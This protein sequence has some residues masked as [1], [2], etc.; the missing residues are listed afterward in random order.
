MLVAN[1]LFDFD[2]L[3]APDE[4]FINLNNLPSTTH[5]R[6][7][8]GAHSLAKAVTHEPRGLQ[9]DAKRTGKLVRANALLAGAKQKGSLKPDMQWNV[10]FLEDGSD[11]DG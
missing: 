2:A 8:S 11:A 1:A 7:V 9:R 6:K 3:L 5:G 4:R 10:T